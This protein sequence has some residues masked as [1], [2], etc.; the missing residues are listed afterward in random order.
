MTETLPLPLPLPLAL[1]LALALAV[2]APARADPLPDIPRDPMQPPALA[3]ASVSDGAAAAAPQLLARHLFVVD[4]QRYVIDG[5]RR[6]AVG[7]LLGGARIE[8]IDDSAVIVR[9]DSGL[10]RLPLFAG[11]T[12]QAIADPAVPATRSARTAPAPKPRTPPNNRRG[13]PQ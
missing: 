2:A 11:V 3:R 6:R 7:D 10:Q 8:R 13:H 12:K 9:S 1:A 5:G 4:G